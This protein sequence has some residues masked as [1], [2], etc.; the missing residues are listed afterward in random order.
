[1]FCIAVVASVWIM[2]TQPTALRLADALDAVITPY[3]LESKAAAELRRLHAEV[4]A[5]RADAGRYRWLRENSTEYSLTQK[6][7]FGG[8][9]LMGWEALDAAIDAARS[10]T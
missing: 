10:K 6:D 5:L 7:S 4:E 1:L 2:T 8:R 3:S 9:E